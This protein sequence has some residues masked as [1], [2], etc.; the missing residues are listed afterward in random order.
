MLDP[1]EREQ[2]RGSAVKWGVPPA[3]LQMLME[4]LDEGEPLPV[5]NLK[6]L[7]R[8]PEAAHL[9]GAAADARRREDSPPARPTCSRRS[10][11]C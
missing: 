6:L 7:R 9:G 4:R 8:K 5:P 2:I 11:S 3:E 10:K 1:E